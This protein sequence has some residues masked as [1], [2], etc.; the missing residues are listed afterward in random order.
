MNSCLK[1]IVCTA[2]A[3]MLLLGGV[4]Y[5]AFGAQPASS[6]AKTNLND[7]GVY[8]SIDDIFNVYNGKKVSMKVSVWASGEDGERVTSALKAGTDYTASYQQVYYRNDKLHV[9]KKLSSAPKNVGYYRIIVK[10]KGAYTGTAKQEFSIHPPSGPKIKKLKGGKRSFTITW[11]RLKGKKAAQTDGYAIGYST[12]SW[13]AK[14]SKFKWIHVK[15][16]KNTKATVKNLK[17]GKKYYVMIESYK[18]VKGNN[19]MGNS[20]YGDTVKVR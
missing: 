17:S 11:R 14:G 2:S 16:L 7:S 4:P 9:W 6:A 3:G 13:Y 10:G 8:V 20:V 15:G 19:I 12:K 18:N 1:T 5:A